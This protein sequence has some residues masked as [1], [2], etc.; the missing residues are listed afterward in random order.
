MHWRSILEVRIIK[1][2]RSVSELHLVYVQSNISQSQIRRLV[3]CLLRYRSMLLARHARHGRMYSMGKV[4]DL[5]QRRHSLGAPSDLD[6]RQQ[7]TAID[8][9]IAIRS[10]FRVRHNNGIL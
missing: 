6:T 10:D 7:A 2:T 8:I 3:I 5:D 1:N 9:A 4:T